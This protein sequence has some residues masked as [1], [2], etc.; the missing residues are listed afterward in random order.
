MSRQKKLNTHR[1]NR[2]GFTLVELLIVIIIIG[3]LAGMMMISTGGATDSAEATRVVN[4]LRNVKSACLMFYADNGKWPVAGGSITSLDQYVDPAIML[5]AF[6]IVDAGNGRIRVQVSGALSN[7]TWDVGSGIY[8]K[9]QGMAEK[10]AIIVG[11]DA[12]AT[13]PVN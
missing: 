8:K 4:N 5:S 1:K 10:S 12:S 13:I 3:I 2:K 6:S 11:N 9:L 7:P